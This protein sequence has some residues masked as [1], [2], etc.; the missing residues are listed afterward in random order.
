MHVP[1]PVLIR[2]G[3]G[4]AAYAAALAALGAWPREATA[5]LREVAHGADA[6]RA[7]APLP[8]PA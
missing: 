3:A 7:A 5:T 4:V 2:A 1:G 6:A 8:L